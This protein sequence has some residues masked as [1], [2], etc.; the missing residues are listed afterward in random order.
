MKL[1]KILRHT[2]GNSAPL[3]LAIVLAVV[4]TGFV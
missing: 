1:G 3:T 4:M 2:S